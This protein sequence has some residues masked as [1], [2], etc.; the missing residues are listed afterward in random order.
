MADDIIERASEFEPPPARCVESCTVPASTSTGKA[1]AAI[2]FD[3]GNTVEELELMVKD[4]V[5][6]DEIRE[7]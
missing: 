2:L 3:G 6:G 5:N 7:I 4:L 1:L